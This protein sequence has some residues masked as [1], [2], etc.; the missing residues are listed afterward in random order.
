MPST[1]EAP[2]N[3]KQSLAWQAAVTRSF[4]YAFLCRALAYPTAEHRAA[5]QERIVPALDQMDVAN[6]TAAARRVIPD[7]LDDM[8]AEHTAIF[9]IT[10]SP[11]C[12]D[13]E[14]AYN[15]NDIVQQTQQM[16]DVGGFYRAHGLEPGGSQT[17]RPDHITTEL[18]FMSFLALKEAYA[19][20]TLGADEIDMTREAQSLFLRDHLGCWGPGLGGRIEARAGSASPF[21]AATGGLLTNWLSAECARLEVVPA[22]IITEPQLEWPE[23]DDGAC[24]A[25]GDS[26]LIGLHEIE[27]LP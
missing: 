24:G 19:I 16:A 12:P 9:S 3:G 20:E 13:Y 14:S 6:E 5:L 7:Q 15:S 17:E 25:A 27:V 23:P 21:Y 11:D 8:R 22:N 2:T 1:N 4:I 26:P 18:E 10:V